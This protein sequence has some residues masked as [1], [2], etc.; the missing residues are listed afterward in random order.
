MS[1]AFTREDDDAPDERVRPKP[2]PALPPGA[3]NWVTADGFKRFQDELQSLQEQRSA[4]TWNREMEQRLVDLEYLLST[5][6]VVAA[7]DNNS[8][9][10]RFGSMVTVRDEAGE[11]QK[12]RIVGLDETDTDCCWV[13]WISPIARTLM[14]TKLGQRVKFRFPAG[15]MELL[16]TA[17]TEVG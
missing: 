8:H 13:S 3:T 2:N 17:I 11:E 15:E 6:E 4:P 1:K 7:T 14:G 12:Y 5:V 10:V 16:V 9:E